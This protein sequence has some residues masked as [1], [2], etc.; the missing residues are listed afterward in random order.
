[1]GDNDISMQVH[2]LSQM[3]H[4][5]VDVDNGGGCTCMGPR[6]MWEIS[7]SSTQFWCVPKTALKIKSNSEKKNTMLGA[8]AKCIFTDLIS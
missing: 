2:Q 8:D 5:V 6:S 4:S 1:M 7:V 3:Y